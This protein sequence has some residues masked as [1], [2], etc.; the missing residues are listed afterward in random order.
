MASVERNRAERKI[1]AYT[2]ALR[3]VRGLRDRIQAVKSLRLFL[4]RFPRAA[5]VFRGRTRVGLDL[6]TGALRPSDCGAVVA[7]AGYVPA[8]RWAGAHRELESKRLGP[9][10]QAWRDRCCAALGRGALLLLARGD[11]GCLFGM[12]GIRDAVGRMALA[13]AGACARAEFP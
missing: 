11:A 2:S 12:G 5:P 9:L 7:L 3:E 10:L 6:A 1:R 4:E 13:L 8:S